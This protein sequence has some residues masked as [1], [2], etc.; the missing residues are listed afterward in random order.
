MKNNWKKIKLSELC[1]IKGGKRLPFGKSLSN[2]VTSHPYIRVRDLTNIKTLNITSEFGYID[3]ETYNQISRYIV[4]TDDVIISIVGTVGLVS[5]IGSTLNNANL[6]EN[7]AKLVN[8]KNIDNNFLYYYLVSSFGQDEIK[9]NSV[10]AVQQKLPIY[11]IENIDIF[12]PPLETQKKI[13]KV[14]SSFDN[15]IELNNKINENLEQQAQA[16]FKSW[17]IDFEP[18]GGK[19]PNDWKKGTFSELIDYAIGGD[20]GKEKIH[21]NYT[22]K[23]YCIRGAD[24]PDVRNGNKGKM[25]FR[26]ILPKNYENKKLSNGDLVVEISGGSPTQSTGRIAVITDYLLNRYDNKI[27]CTNF[28]RA[29]KPKKDYSMFIYYY[30]LYMYSKDVFF[31]YENGTTGIK[32]F[33]ITGFLE[34]EKIVIPNEKVLKNFSNLCISFEKQIFS[35]GYENE[36]LANLRDTLLPKLIINGEIEL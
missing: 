17:F 33:D 23:V 30:W 3:N 6:T 4:N 1:K 10:G 25:P 24:I 32:N 2:K 31:S 35:N 16:I 22:E 8:L 15:K 14:L 19:M 28:C 9:K 12:L 11:G 27:V 13:A 5:I 29:L 20:W 26:Y 36:Q 21:E 7:C 18:F 34:T